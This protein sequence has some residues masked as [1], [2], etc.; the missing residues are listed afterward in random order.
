MS[1]TLRFTP[2]GQIECIYTEAIDLRVLG[3]LQVFRATD[4]RFCEK[5]QEWKVRCA[6]TGKLL[7]TD[8]SRG[9]CL[10]WERHHLQP[11]TTRTDNP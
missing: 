10:A 9:V 3:R 6:A 8:P 4:I 1:H 7:H 11:G 5:S 2:S